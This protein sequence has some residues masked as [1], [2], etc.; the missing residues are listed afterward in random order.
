MNTYQRHVE[1]ME[2]APRLLI[3]ECIKGRVYKIQSRN[4]TYGVF[5]GK[6]GFIGIRLKFSSRYLFTEYHW[7]QGP[8][9]GTVYGVED[10]G[11]TVSKHVQDNI[12]DDDVRLSSF[13]NN[14]ESKQLFGFLD[15]F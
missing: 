5:D 14:D 11:L 2:N 1:R 10:T 12:E 3:S 7:D 4:L 15:G 13:A 8:P 9:Y 6:D